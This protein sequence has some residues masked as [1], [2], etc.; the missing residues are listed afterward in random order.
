MLAMTMT[1]ALLQVPAPAPPPLPASDRSALSG[2]WSVDLSVEPGAPYVQPMML[3][4][5]V[6]GTLTGSFYRSDIEAGR[7]KGQNGRL[8][9]SFRTTDGVGPY[10]TAA[11]LVGEPVE[12]QTWASS[13][14]SSSSGT[15]PGPR[16][17]PPPVPPALELGMPSPDIRPCQT[18][19]P[20]PTIRC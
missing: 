3:A 18:P 19:L 16:S 4:L 15:R 10:H 13:G 2:A 12:G 7:W 9:V 20:R 11:C 6:D 1:A 5:E 8:C 14:I 17:K